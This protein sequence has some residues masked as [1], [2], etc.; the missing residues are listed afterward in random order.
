MVSEVL[1]NSNNFAKI[2]FTFWNWNLTP[3]YLY[4]VNI[5][6]GTRIITSMAAMPTNVNQEFCPSNQCDTSDMDIAKS[7][8]VRNLSDPKSLMT[9]L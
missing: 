9:S 1:F 2:A 3:Q 5:I 6:T 4:S 7:G 8:L